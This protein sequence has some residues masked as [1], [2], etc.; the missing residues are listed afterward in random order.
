M[1]SSDLLELQTLMSGTF[2]SDLQA[3]QDSNFLNVQLFMTPIWTS[4][5]DGVWLY[6]E[7]AMAQQL[8]KPYR[9]RVY[10]LERYE[11][12]KYL[13]KVFTIHEESRFAGCYR[14]PE[15][16]DQLKPADLVAKES[17]TVYLEQ[18]GKKYFKGSTRGLSCESLL[19]GASYATSEVEITDGEIISYD[20][21]FAKNGLQVWGSKTGPYRFLKL[22]LE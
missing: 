14:S 9:Q 15:K 11:K 13:S 4:D 19:R 3:F 2:S 5:P 8:S 6:V 21:G 7:Q 16:L 1:R 20:R 22:P 17:C 18:I 12:G 10:K